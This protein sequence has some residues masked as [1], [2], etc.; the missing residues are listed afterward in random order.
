MSP[1]EITQIRQRLALTQ[2]ELAALLGVHLVTV[3]RW[4]RGTLKP[5]NWH[6]SVL[7]VFAA[8]AAR[9]PKAGRKAMA[10]VRPMDMAAVPKALFYL[11]RVGLAFVPCR[12]CGGASDGCPSC[13]GYGMVKP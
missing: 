5:S 6:L 7:A 2:A 8:A 3:S 12:R 4:E 9:K 11:F 10:L 13:E 1:A